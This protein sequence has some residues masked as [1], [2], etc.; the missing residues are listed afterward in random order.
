MS[1]ILAALGIIVGGASSIF[2]LL[3]AF[4]VDITPDQ[5]TAIVAVAG[6]LMLVL[7]LWFHPAVPIGEQKKP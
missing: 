3:T 2:S 5:H 6:V 4:G 1:K 7:G